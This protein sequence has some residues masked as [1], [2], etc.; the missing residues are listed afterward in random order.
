[1]CKRAV[2]WLPGVR[3]SVWDF[4]VK[5]RVTED[6]SESAL[7]L[8]TVALL[9]SS[10]CNER[11]VHEREALGQ[12]QCAIWHW[13]MSVKMYSVDGNRSCIVLRKIQNQ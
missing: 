10:K 3:L 6:A 9:S 7:F 4:L 11:M 2:E 13:E 5:S 12:N 1:L 8:R